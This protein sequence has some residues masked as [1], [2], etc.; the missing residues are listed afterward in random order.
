MNSEAD[1]QLH[2][3][4]LILARTVWVVIAVLAVVPIV[5]SIPQNY[6]H[7]LNVCTQ[8]SC[9]N[10]QATPDMVRALH[11]VG[12]SLQFYALYLTT[13]EIVFVLIFCVIGVIIA[14]RKSRDW[15]ALLVSLTLVIIGTATFT[16]YQQ[17][18]LA[19]LPLTKSL[20]MCILLLLN[21]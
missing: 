13:L 1:T 11:S 8:A 10:Q 6:A 15:M 20:P 4:K 18:E 9:P 12:L 14:W 17:L 5:I 19:Y 2:G 3:Y 7:Y 21:C 16:Q